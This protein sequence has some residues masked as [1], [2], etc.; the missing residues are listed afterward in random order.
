M[1]AE[2]KNGDRSAES[3]SGAISEFSVLQQRMG[4]RIAEPDRSTN[5]A[6]PEWRERKKEGEL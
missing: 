1:V 2:N 3:W 4:S 6:D 5:P